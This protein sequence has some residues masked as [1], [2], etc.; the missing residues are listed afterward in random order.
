MNPVTEI[1]RSFEEYFWPDYGVRIY[2]DDQFD[3]SFDV[4]T[5]IYVCGIRR[6]LE[7]IT[8]Q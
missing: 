7:L 3:K 6:N 8:Y 5:W 2:Q 4:S 1:Y